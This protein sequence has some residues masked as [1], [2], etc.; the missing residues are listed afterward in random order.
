MNTLL[1]NI[2][3]QCWILALFIRDDGER[4]LLGDGA[5]VFTQKQQHFA[6]DNLS[7]DTVEIQGGDGVLLAGQVRRATKQ[8]FKGYIGDGSFSLTDTEAARRALLGFFLDNHFYQVVYIMKGGEAI[9]RK[10]G[11]LVS[12]PEVQEIYQVQPEY[13]VELNFEDVNYC[14][15]AEDENGDEIFARTLDAITASQTQF[16]ITVSRTVATAA[17]IDTFRITFET[18]GNDTTDSLRIYKVGVGTYEYTM[19]GSLASGHTLVIDV[20]KGVASATLD[21]DEVSLTV[22]SGFTL[23]P[24]DNIFR[25]TSDGGSGRAIATIQYSGVVA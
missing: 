22:N 17:P 7:N 18:V 19:G 4:F 11:F 12:M 5:Y 10:R 21:G 24:G 15:Y 14:E 3:K 25:V 6:A 13:N 2:Q 1:A 9:T 23:T 20:V 8:A 16:P